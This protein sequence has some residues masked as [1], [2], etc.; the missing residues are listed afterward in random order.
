MFERLFGDR[1]A[2]PALADRVHGLFARDGVRPAATSSPPPLA[3][4]SI[5]AYPWEAAAWQTI[6]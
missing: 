4:A 2:D 1:R 3:P 5:G 6:A